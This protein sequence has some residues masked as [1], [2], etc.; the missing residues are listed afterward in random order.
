MISKNGK[1]DRYCKVDGPKYRSNHDDIFS[2]KPKKPK[3]D[4]RPEY[5]CD[6]CPKDDVCWYPCTA[7]SLFQYR[8]KK[9]KA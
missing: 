3:Y 8:E 1:G 9:I 4:P 7:L 5:P 2:T 6:G